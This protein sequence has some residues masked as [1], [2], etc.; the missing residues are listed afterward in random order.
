MKEQEQFK[1]LLESIEQKRSRLLALIEE[2]EW[3]TNSEICEEI[4]SL[5]EGKKSV[6]K[7][8]FQFSRE[9]D[10]L[11][12]EVDGFS[13]MKQCVRENNFYGARIPISEAYK[14]SAHQFLFDT[15]PSRPKDYRGEYPEKARRKLEI[16]KLMEEIE[17]PTVRHILFEKGDLVTETPPESFRLTDSEDIKVIIR[18]WRPNKERVWVKSAR[19]WAG[20]PDYNDLENTYHL[21]V[22]LADQNDR[23]IKDFG[24]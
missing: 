1:N 5:E 22:S 19:Y 10:M 14:I 12:R 8:T 2:E 6:Y 9:K 20:H 11:D 17:P 15:L 13:L 21:N 18:I 3:P 4:S 7:A 24:K 16:L 23:I